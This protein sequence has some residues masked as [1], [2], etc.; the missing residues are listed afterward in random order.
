MCVAEKLKPFFPEV[1]KKICE[2]DL[3]RVSET[4]IG[5]INRLMNLAIQYTDTLTPFMQIGIKKNLHCQ[6]YKLFFPAS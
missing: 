1:C 4:K 3:P 5:N 6:V 2:D